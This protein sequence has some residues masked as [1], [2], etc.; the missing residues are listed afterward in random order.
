MCCG[1]S[2]FNR[3]ANE[4]SVESGAAEVPSQNEDINQRVNQLCAT[5]R[6]TLLCDQSGEV[7][8]R[9]ALL[10]YFQVNGHFVFHK[11]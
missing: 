1:S 6:T 9:F 4:L 2:V 3:D 11:L 8:D 7:A 10:L 5:S